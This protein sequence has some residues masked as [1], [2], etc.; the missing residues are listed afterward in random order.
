M[1]RRSYGQPCALAAALDQVGDLWAL[2]VVREL[3]FGPRRFTELAAGLPGVGS[4]TLTGRLKQLE[5]DGVIARRWLPPPAAST[6]YAL[7][8]RGQQLRPI[9]LALA[10]WGAP[11][12]A[13]TP[14]EHPVRAN[15]LGIALEAFYVPG[16]LAAMVA[17][18]D[19]PTGR[20]LVTVADGAL[21]VSEGELVGPGIRVRATEAAVLGALQRPEALAALV[22]AGEIA[23]EGDGER[24]LALLRAC[25]I[26]RG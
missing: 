16:T 26:P 6:V 11:A 17:E 5:A 22:E 19:M 2:L 10:R 23:V 21:T 13:H 24:L 8:P 25:P 7:T 18:L 14:F 20:L 9:V 4:N 15:W 12:L 3:L 1:S